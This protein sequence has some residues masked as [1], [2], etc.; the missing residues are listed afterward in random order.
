MSGED[1]FPLTPLK[2]INTSIKKPSQD[3]AVNNLDH[4]A[5]G[6]HKYGINVS[7]EK[8]REAKTIIKKILGT[9]GSYQ[10]GFAGAF[11]VFSALFRGA[12]RWA[13]SCLLP[14]LSSS[15]AAATV[16]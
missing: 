7:G 3:L 14:R 6:L 8:V 16:D 10:G 5:L 15:S 2:H 13:S 4:T 9:L 12:Q 1:R 11:L